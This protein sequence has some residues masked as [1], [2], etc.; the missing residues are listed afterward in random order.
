M[1]PPAKSAEIRR[2]FFAEHWRIGTIASELGVHPDTVR[3]VINSDAFAP[4][5]RQVRSTLLDPYKEFI[6]QT[7]EKH[8]RLRATRLYEMLTPRGYAGS[9]IQLRR[10]VKTVRPRGKREAFLRLETLPGEQGQVDW[11]SFGKLTVGGATRMLSCF[12]LVLSCSRAMFARFFLSQTTDCFLQGHV[13]A[14]EA[15]G[16]VPRI[17]LYDNLKSVVVERDGD[18][19]RLNRRILELAG[20]YHFA[21][22]SLC[23]LSR[24]RERQGGTY[25]SIYSRLLFCGP[26]IH[27][28]GGPQWSA[29]AMDGR[30]RAPADGARR[31]LATH[32]R[33]GARRGA[34]TPLIT[35]AEPIFDGS[36]PAGAGDEDAVYQI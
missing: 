26:E 32:R 35:A 30:H 21:P 31:P 13:E 11:S 9:V 33:T 29:R 7:L 16:G 3:R 18:L 24:E 28:G 6:A 19:M 8:P 25:D 36:H 34:P 14:F 1:I 4:R 22:P 17:L 27:I 5:P 15:L 12:V 2:L 20:H 10:Y 23:A